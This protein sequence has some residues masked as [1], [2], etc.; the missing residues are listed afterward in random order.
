MIPPNIRSLMKY[1]ECVSLQF[2]RRCASYDNTDTC[3]F[4]APFPHLSHICSIPF[5]IGLGLDNKI[6]N[7]ICTKSHYSGIDKNRLRNA[8]I[9]KRIDFLN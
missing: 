8:N 4:S 1:M 9:F 3:T 5:E 6:N 2:I 7:D